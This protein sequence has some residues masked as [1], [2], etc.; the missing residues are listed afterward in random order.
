MENIKLSDHFYLYEFT[1]SQI[2]ERYGINN[3]PPFEVI[4]NIIALCTN[5]LEPARNLMGTAIIISSGYRCPE[6]NKII[7]GSK[8]SQHQ[9]GEAG[10]I[11][12]V[13]DQ[14]HNKI[15]FDIIKNDLEFDQMIWEFGND[16]F[17]AW[18]HVSFSRL[19]NRGEI[20]KA[21]Y[22][23]PKGTIYEKLN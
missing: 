9:R 22:K 5:V 7:G 3:N 19:K 17:P 6:L 4:Q 13:L 21:R 10:D 16:N 2:A 20:L 12:S 23:K 8:L 1:Q 15:M 11:R 18:V 14:T